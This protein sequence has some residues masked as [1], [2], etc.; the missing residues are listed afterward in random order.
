M[1][2]KKAEAPKKEVVKP[3]VKAIDR[4]CCSH[5]ISVYGEE[6]WCCPHFPYPNAA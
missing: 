5:D 1:L 3:V 4:H 2:K 6:H